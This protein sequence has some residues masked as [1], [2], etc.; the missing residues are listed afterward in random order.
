[1][2]SGGSDGTTLIAPYRQYRLDLAE[3]IVVDQ[4]TVLHR[5]HDHLAFHWPCEGAD[6]PV[7]EPARID[8]A[9][10]APCPPVT[11]SR[12]PGVETVVPEMA[13]I[14][15]VR[16]IACSA[17]CCRCNANGRAHSV[18]Y[19]DGDARVA[20]R[21]PSATSSRA[22]PGLGPGDRNGSTRMTATGVEYGRS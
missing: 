2:D 16:H 11:G 13:D 21:G 10:A 12:S 22:R 6:T 18:Q 5:M 20:P 7:T 1:V 9:G 14:F 19:R 15:R 3:P 4:R 8:G 17:G